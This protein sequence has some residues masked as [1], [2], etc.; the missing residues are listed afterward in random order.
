MAV[1]RIEARLIDAEGVDLGAGTAAIHLPLGRGRAQQASGTL[2]LRQWNPSGGQPAA[3]LTDE[4][5]RLPIE[6]SRDAIS[7]CSRS[8]I[9]RFSAAWQPAD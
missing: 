3:L 8:R 9:L 4:I 7:D 1:V 2:A 6:V 5:G